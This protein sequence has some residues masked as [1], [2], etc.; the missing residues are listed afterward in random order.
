MK[1][2]IE[3][4]FMVL[5]VDPKEKVDLY[6]LIDLENGDKTTSVGNK[7]LEDLKQFDVVKVT[8]AINVKQEK[9][10]TKKDGDK[11]L[12]LANIFISSV[13]KVGK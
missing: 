2:T 3:K 11:Y 6:T 13:E 8:I 5:K 7:C 4:S 9:I 10:E 12:Q 1:F